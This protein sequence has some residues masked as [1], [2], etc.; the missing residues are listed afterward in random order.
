MARNA[1]RL[2][3]DLRRALA[4]FAAAPDRLSIT[5]EDAAGNIILTS[6]TSSPEA[7]ATTGVRH[8]LRYEGALMGHLLA[9]GPDA[10]IPAMAAA[11]ESIAILLGERLHAEAAGPTHHH[12]DLDTELAHG[13]QQQRRMVSLIAP[14]VTGYELASHYEAARQVGGDFFE[15]FRLP[16]RGRPLGVVIADV[17]GKGITAALLMAFSRPLIHSAMDHARGPAEA[18]ERTNRILVEERRSTLFI[19]ALAATIDLSTGRM[20]LA[21]AGHEPPL[22]MPGN[23]SAIRPLGEAGVLLGA[24]GSLGLGET[25]TDLAPGDVVVCYTDG[26]TDALGPS[27]DRF[28]DD[29]LLA[30][31]EAARGGSAQDV[32]DAIRDAVDGFCASIEPADD[33]TIVAIG[34]QRG[35]A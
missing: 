21:N 32:L 10:G 3:D 16:R 13:R 22:L 20:R 24:F 6:G 31:I 35:V 30:T 12:H 9:E 2:H 23:G 28:G 11:I 5:L 27:D 18:L 33:I 19:T 25:L 7:P 14:E 1:P 8:E 29:R 26:V 34:R 17:T 15:L 4:P